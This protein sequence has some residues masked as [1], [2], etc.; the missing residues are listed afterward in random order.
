MET[1]AKLVSFISASPFPLPPCHPVPSLHTSQYHCQT[2]VCLTYKSSTHHQLPS[3]CL[4]VQI[5][6]IGK[7]LISLWKAIE[8]VC[9][10]PG[11]HP[12]QSAMV[13]VVVMVKGEQC[14][15]VWGGF[16]G[17]GSSQKG[18]VAGK[19]L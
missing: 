14:H 18:T 17:G 19:P 6:A 10:G 16:R 15:M 4:S 11:V 2:F 9:L 5:L 7:T 13:G 12:V 8:L 1:R 3:L